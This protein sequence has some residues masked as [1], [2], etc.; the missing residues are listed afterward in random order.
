MVKKRMYLCMACSMTII[1]LLTA[2]HKEKGKQQLY[3]I[4]HPRELEKL[5]EIAKVQS[6]EASNEIEGIRTTDT[7]LRQL[8]Q[9][10]TAPRNKD[11]SVLNANGNEPQDT[12]SPFFLHL[13]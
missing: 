3:L 6:T 5:V 9:D 11:K 4:Q 10:K 13:N 2:I 7:R 8:M 1:N 12:Q